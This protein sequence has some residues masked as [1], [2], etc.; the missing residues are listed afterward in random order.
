MTPRKPHNFRW[1]IKGKLAG[2]SQPFV[3]NNDDGDL[4][5]LKEQGIRAIVSLTDSPLDRKVLQNQGF[6][7]AH[8][9]VDDGSAPSLDQIEEFV[10]TVREWIKRDRGVVVHCSAGCGRTGTMLAC[11]LVSEGEKARTAIRKVRRAAPCSIE[12]ERQE[13]AVRDWES[14]V[15]SRKK[16]P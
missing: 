15:R 6:G 5:Y 7:Y 11:Y 3:A 1:Q 2:M 8:L 9:P 4:A 14:V 16:R 13:Q 10:D 12:N